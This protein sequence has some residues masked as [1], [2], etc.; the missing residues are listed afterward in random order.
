MAATNQQH[1]AFFVSAG[2]QM[3]KSKTH[4]LQKSEVLKGKRGRTV[5]G[6]LATKE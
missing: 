4:T 1:P 6:T 2:K 5:G 3:Q